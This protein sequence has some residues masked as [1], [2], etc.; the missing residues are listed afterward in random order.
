MAKMQPKD[1]V[2]DPV[3][4]ATPDQTPYAAGVDPEAQA[5]PEVTAEEQ[6]V[7]DAKAKVAEAQKTLNEA[8][9]VHTDAVNVQKEAEAAAAPKPEKGKHI[10]VE[11]A[12]GSY[13]M[14][15]AP[16]GYEGG[17]PAA[18]ITLQGRN[19]EHVAEHASGIWVYR[20][21]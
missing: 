20:S 16:E 5:A 6:A 2:V 21:M 4:D 7:A 13:L 14:R 15:D 3:V 10:F 11:G 19:Y 9:A 12:D 8:T 17:A 18:R 1:P